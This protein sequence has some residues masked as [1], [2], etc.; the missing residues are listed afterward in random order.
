MIF[1]SPFPD[2]TIPDAALTPFLLRHATRLGD[3]PAL[4]EGET[5]RTLT[6]AQ[7]A[8][9][10]ERLA[11]GLAQRGFRQ[12]DVLA[13]YCQNSPEYIMTLLAV[14]SLGGAVTT[15]NPLFTVREI[16]NQLADSKPKFLLTTPDVLDKASEAA[17]ACG[18]EHIILFGEAP[19]TIAFAQL[20]QSEGAPPPVTINPRHDVATLLYSSGTTGFPKGVML[21]HYNIVANICQL[22]PLA[23][24]SEGEV[25]VVGL[26]FFHI[27]AWGIFLHMGLYQGAT[28]I[29]LA[30]FELERFLRVSQDYRASRTLLVPPIV[31]ALAK[32][33]IVDQYQLA[34]KV[35]LVGAAPLGEA[36]ARACEQRIGCVIQQVYGLSE[37]SPATHANPDD[38]AKIKLASVGP[39][40]P[41]TE[42]KVVDLV[43]GE[44]LGANQQGELCM[45]GPQ[46][47]LGYLNRPDATAQAIEPEGWFHSGDIGYADDE[48]YFYI[49]DRVKE[50][51]K[52][53]ALQVAPAELE[54]VLLAHPAVADAA[55][56]PSP[57]EEAGEVPKA[58]VVLKGDAPPDMTPEALMAFV[59]ER[60]APYKKIRRLE[61]IDQIPKTTSGKI[62]RR[63]LVERER[64]ARARQS[65]GE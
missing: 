53:K 29:T 45:R 34:Y 52:Y 58:F 8:S 17:R 59:A 43:T 21:S 7:L 23:R 51:I 27:A 56:I 11:V 18:I 46:V 36:V 33:P 3:T 61:F 24:T 16:T 15:L 30:R 25:M 28:I 47:M 10:V 44:A 42:C 48:G 65:M 2:V 55:V 20:L 6:Y 35:F 22:A 54:A 31:L 37:T 14:W 49:V 13:I 62:L 1:S 39:C 5:G 40:V 4:I 63:L 60:V 32:Q 38:L 64:A 9:A 41:N 26:P 12:G 50:L 19:G 57:D